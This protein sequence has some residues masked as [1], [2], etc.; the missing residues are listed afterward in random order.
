MPAQEEMLIIIENQ[1]GPYLGWTL[2]RMKSCAIFR[3]H[4]ES[5][6]VSKLKNHV[7]EAIAKTQ[8]L[9]GVPEENF[10]LG[11]LI[12]LERECCIKKIGMF[13]QSIEEATWEDQE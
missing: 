11:P 7:G 1:R 5:I 12:V 4:F 13:Y 9:A 8:L 2:L 10:D 6:P 3:N